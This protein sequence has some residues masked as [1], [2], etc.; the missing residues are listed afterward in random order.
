MRAVA[1]VSEEM[2]PLLLVWRRF[3]RSRPSDVVVDG[4]GRE[5]GRWQESERQSD[6]TG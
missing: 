3:L 2:S 6:Q 4:P 5:V 1:Y